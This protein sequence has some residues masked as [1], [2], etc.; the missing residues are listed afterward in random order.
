MPPR[1]EIRLAKEDFKFSVAHFT[2]FG[3]GRAE[4]LHG[5][6]YLMIVEVSGPA[7][8]DLGLLLDL[9]VVKRK[10]RA[11]C[12]GLDSKTLIPELCPLLTVARSDGQVEVA[13]E[14]REYSFP[15]ADTLLLPIVNTTL[16]ELALYSWR[17][18]A[19][20]LDSSAAVELSV[21]VAET[22]GQSCRYR[23]VL[24]DLE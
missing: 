3:P 19:E 20:E 21:E 16:E 7:T 13:F 14:E 17:A 18:I 6:N 12:A 4:R 15:E 22:P 11:L 5:H 1:Y 10:I 23:A 9:E 8:D 24:G 2:I